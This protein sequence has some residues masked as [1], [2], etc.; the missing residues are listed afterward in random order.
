M[1]IWKF[2]AM[3]LGFIISCS[4]VALIY[5]KAKFGAD[6][7]TLKNHGES[8]K[9]L[10]D[11]FSEF[12]IIFGKIETH[13]EYIKE[14]NIKIHEEIKSVPESIVK[15]FSDLSKGKKGK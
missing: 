3:V 13:I 10:E 6:K 14:D 15:L 9:G 7:D 2:F 4:T 8:I 1:D 5:S 12:K 11:D